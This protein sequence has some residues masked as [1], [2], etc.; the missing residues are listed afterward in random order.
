MTADAIVVFD[1][2]LAAEP[3]FRAKRAGRLASGMRFRAARLDACPAGDRGCATRPT[4]APRPSG[5]GK[6]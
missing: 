1:R 5:S 6:V 4:R 3:A 2:S